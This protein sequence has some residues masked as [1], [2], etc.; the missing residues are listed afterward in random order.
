MHFYRTFNN[1]PKGADLTIYCFLASLEKWR[2][3]HPQRLFPEEIYIQVDGGSENA[4]QYLL[5]MLELL[6]VKRMVR[7][8][9][10]SRLPTGHTHEDIDATF[11]HLWR[12]MRQRTVE[13]VDQFKEGV[14]EMFKSTELKA[15]VHD[16]YVIPDYKRFFE[17]DGGSIDPKLQGYTRL[18]NTQHRWTFEY[19]DVSINFPLGCK[20]MYRAFSSDVV[21]EFTKRHKHQCITELGQITGLEGVTTLSKWYPDGDTF[22]SRKGVEGFYLLTKVPFVRSKMDMLPME[23]AEHSADAIADTMS[24]VRERWLH[25]QEG[26]RREQWENGTKLI[27]RKISQPQNISC[28]ILTMYHFAH[29]SR[30]VFN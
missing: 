17:N 24:E 18:I 25:G 11:A 13:T 23:F 10:Y 15:Q 7:K 19:V 28:H 6:V 20:V 4:N 12:W 30:P 5:A 27:V 29:I 2:L 14:E 26:D 16:V 1:V 3:N 9:V 21:V 22:P 8:I